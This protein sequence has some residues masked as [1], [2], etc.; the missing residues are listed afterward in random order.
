MMSITSTTPTTLPFFATTGNV[1]NFWSC[2]I[3]IASN[4]VISGKT[5][6]G[7]GV[8]TDDTAVSSKGSSFATQRLIQSLK[9]KIPTSSPSSTTNAAFLASAILI[10][11][12]RT[13]VPGFTTVDARPCRILPSVG[14]DLFPNAW[15]IICPI[16]A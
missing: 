2:M 15:A 11:Q 13:F 16:I 7:L 10:A 4:T 8:I 14:I 12:S 1:K 9:P 6:S 3:C 5:V